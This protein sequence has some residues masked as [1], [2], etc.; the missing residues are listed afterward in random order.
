MRDNLSLPQK[1]KQKG[2]KKKEKIGIVI[3]I[4]K[5]KID[6]IKKLESE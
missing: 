5:P 1:Y 3:G 6:K 4:I 2:V